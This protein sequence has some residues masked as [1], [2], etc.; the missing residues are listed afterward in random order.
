[1]IRRP[2][3]RVSAHRLGCT[4]DQPYGVMDGP[5]IDR[6]CGRVAGPS[7]RPTGPFAGSRATSRCPSSW[8]PCTDTLTPRR[9]PRPPKLSEPPRSVHPGSPPKFHETRDILPDSC[10]SNKHRP[11]QV[12]TSS[13]Q[14]SPGVVTGAVSRRCQYPPVLSLAAGMSRM[15]LRVQLLVDGLRRACTRQIGRWGFCILER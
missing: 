1:M 4:G 6:P 14:G 15:A 9:R 7:P 5:I 3:G 2:V 12:C 13:G 8:P 11:P 10:R